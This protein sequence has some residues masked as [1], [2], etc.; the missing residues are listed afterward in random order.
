MRSGSPSI[1]K[2]ATPNTARGLVFAAIETLASK[3]TPDEYRI[4]AVALNF[5]LSYAYECKKG[6]LR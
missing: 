1:L 4:L 5:S 6:E 3:F 2:V